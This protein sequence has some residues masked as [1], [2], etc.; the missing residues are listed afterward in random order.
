M[1]TSLSYPALV[2]DWLITHNLTICD[3]IILDK[4]AGSKS[5]VS[6]DFQRFKPRAGRQNRLRARLGQERTRDTREEAK[7]NRPPQ[8]E[9]LGDAENV[10]SN[11]GAVHIKT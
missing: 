6:V 9:F 4:S 2:F 5:G 3:N 1:Y 11:V 8:P 10:L 7:S